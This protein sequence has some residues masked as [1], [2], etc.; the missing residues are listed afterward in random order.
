MLSKG[1]L[2]LDAERKSFLA[3]IPGIWLVVLASILWST[4]GFFTQSSLLQVWP[5]ENRGA[6]IAFWRACFALVLLLPLV[7]KPTWHWAM[8]P[9]ACC[10]AA[11]NWTY[12]SAVVVGSPTNA[13][14]FQN[15]A[16]VWVMLGAIAIFKERTTE[17][18]WAMLAIC[19]AGVFFILVMESLYGFKSPEYR[20][21]GP[22]L[23]IGSGVCY[24]GVVLSMRALRGH[25]SAWLVGLNHI[26]TAL[27]MLPLIW[28]SGVAMPSGWLWL[29]LAGIGMLQ[30]G[31]PYLLFA[32]GL[33]TTP[34]HL[35]SLITLLEP[36]LMPVWVHLTRAGDPNY[37]IPQWW[38]WV[39]AGSIVLGLM[40]RYLLPAMS[41][42]KS[43]ET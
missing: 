37:R 30:M 24:G 4:G 33:K 19:I 12:L 5:V 2:I 23:A 16:P 25:E 26:V 39:G 21:W 17:R 15:L 13:I 10:F 27:A 14:W 36:V 8:I 3:Y 1:H 35:A 18:D 31:L 42:T 7:R 22:F 43:C 32:S 29:L 9:M 34:S 20:W 28:V 6:A 40:I 38:T 11:M 41:S